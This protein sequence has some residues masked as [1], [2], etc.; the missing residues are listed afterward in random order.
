MIGCFT[1]RDGR[2]SRIRAVTEY[3]GLVIVNGVNAEA[4]VCYLTVL[5]VC[6]LSS[7][8]LADRGPDCR[9]DYIS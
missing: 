1:G 7:H 4:C 8:R 3:K 5:E 2:L 9:D 6:I